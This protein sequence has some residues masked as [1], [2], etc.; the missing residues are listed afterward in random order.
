MNVLRGSVYSSAVSLIQALDVDYGQRHAPAAVPQE[1][2]ATNT[3]TGGW[4]GRSGW[5]EES[6]SLP[7]S[8]FDPATAQPVAS[9]LTD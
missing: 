2:T 9:R 6:L 8:G 4:V 5:C 7:P 3:L 1:K